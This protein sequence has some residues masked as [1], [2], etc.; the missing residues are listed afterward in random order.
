MNRAE[1]LRRIWTG[2]MTVAVVY[3]VSGWASAT[4]G[5]QAQYDY[6]LLATNKTS[7]MQKELSEAAAHG[8]RFAAVM[9]GETSFG[10]SEVV[11]IMQKKR[12]SGEEGRYQYKLLAT[13]RTSTM[14]KELQQ[15]A[16]EGF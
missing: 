3:F 4:A 16:E 14:Q 5:D 12:G 6:R 7:T 1:S 9:G 15:A 10:G 2:P 8:F 13:S 11:I